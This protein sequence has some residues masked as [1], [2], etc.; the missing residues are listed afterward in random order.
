MNGID[1]V[2]V[3]ILSY[4]RCLWYADGED[5]VGHTLRICC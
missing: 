1:R 3:N 4:V 5:L 2:S